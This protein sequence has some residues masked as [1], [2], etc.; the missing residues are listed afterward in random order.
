MG[1]PVPGETALVTT[2]VYAG[3]TG[4]IS[5]V[6]VVLIA[7]MG[8]II[9]DNIGY[10]IG[11]SI[12]IRLVVRYGRYVRLNESALAPVRRLFRPFSLKR[13]PRSPPSLTCRWQ[14]YGA[15]LRPKTYA[16]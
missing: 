7:A 2:A 14:P 4:R 6:A 1:I 15:F 9:G 8:A 12:G 5:I 3:S 10:F 11:R 13:A 16:V